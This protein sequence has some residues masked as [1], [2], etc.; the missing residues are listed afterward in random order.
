M[1]L[2]LG[3]SNWISNIQLLCPTCNLKKYKKHPVDWA[4]ENGLLL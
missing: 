3:G 2:F 1:P 4:R